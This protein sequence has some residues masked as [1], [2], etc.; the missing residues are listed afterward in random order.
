MSETRENRYPKTKLPELENESKLLKLIAGPH[1]RVALE[2]ALRWLHEQIESVSW[3]YLPTK[4][5]VEA[6]EEWCNIVEERIIDYKK[7]IPDEVRGAI[8][9]YLAEVRK[10]YPVAEEKW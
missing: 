8:K 5:E 1:A 10:K 7:E 2:Q 4:Q 9:T 3:P 6:I